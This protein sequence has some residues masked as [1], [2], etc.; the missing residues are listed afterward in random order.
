MSAGQRH[1]RHGEPCGTRGP[2]RRTVRRSAAARAVGA[3]AGLALLAGGLA[4]C[5][6]D[7]PRAGCGWMKKQTP[8][9]G[10]DS[11]VVLVDGSRS[12]HGT[13]SGAPG[14]D[15]G[16][17]VG[18]L[19]AKNDKNDQVVSIGTFGG[20]DADVEWTVQRQPASWRRSNP[21]PGNQEG[22][23]EDANQCLRDDIAAA[24]HKKPAAGGTDVLGALAAGADL[25][26]G[27]RGERRLLVLS[28]GLST[29][30]CANLRSA[31]FGSAPELTSVVSV[32]DS[33]GEFGELPDLRGAHVTFVGLG[34][35]T[36]RQPSANRGQRAWLAKL[37][38]TLCERSGAAHG[39]CTVDNAPVAEGNEPGKE[40]GGSFPDDP[41][42]RF[43]DDGPRTFSLS[44]T[45]LFDTDSARVR[46]KALP[47]LAA[48][49]DNTL[50]RGAL[51]RVV[52]DGYVDP[53]G[54][55]ANDQSLSRARADAV[56]KVLVE[57]GV[58][59]SRVEAHGRGRSP[60][61]PGDKAA[62]SMSRQQ[63]LQCD[64]RVEVRIITK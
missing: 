1:R 45:A 35:S 41:V 31:Q 33:E 25:F 27:V 7:D 39:A 36:G 8:A 59:A 24:Q 52:V 15:Y 28:D 21:N 4:G 11:T 62:A 50:R 18:D 54:G 47:L 38:T 9:A 57:H 63:R 30:G 12:V 48:L 53:R 23:R 43:G 46:P 17:M 34:R 14:L 40:S 64:R 49:A 13:G 61:C 10:A 60:G 26:D 37:W 20:P 56:A 3:L 29:D 58:P 5:G 32:C 42:V 6:S 16:R 19:L 55:T 2:S 44:G 22:N 51:D